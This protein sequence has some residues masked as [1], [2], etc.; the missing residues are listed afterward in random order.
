MGAQRAAREGKS[1]NSAARIGS[2]SPLGATIIEGGANFSLF[3]RGATGVELLFLTTRA[4]LDHHASFPSTLRQTAP[5]IIGTCSSPVW[6]QDKFTATVSREPQIPRREC[7]LIPPSPPRS[8]RSRCGCA[9]ALQPRFGPPGGRQRRDR[10]EK[11]RGRSA[12]LRL[13]RR[14][15]SEP[16]VVAND[17]LRNARARVYAPPKFGCFG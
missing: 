11:C 17:H 3:S 1:M 8:I 5:I 15:P 13:G 12:S 6:N 2:S 16:A 4:T 10:H 14:Y 9:L 7:D